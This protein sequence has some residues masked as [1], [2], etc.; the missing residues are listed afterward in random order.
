MWQAERVLNLNLSQNIRIKVS[1]INLFDVE[2]RHVGNRL[3]R[4]S[5]K[6]DAG[7]AFA[8]I[9]MEA[10]ASVE[11]EACMKQRVED[12]KM[13]RLKRTSLESNSK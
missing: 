13:V 10:E 9:R 5:A 11:A 7:F 4:V 2:E 1:S 8:E 3:K 6:F 12:L